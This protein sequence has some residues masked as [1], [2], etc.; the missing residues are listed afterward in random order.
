M[1]L[2]VSLSE[3]GLHRPSWSSVT[4]LVFIDLSETTTLSLHG[5]SVL[6][7]ANESPPA[8]TTSAGNTL[9]SGHKVKKKTLSTVP[10][11]TPLEGEEITGGTT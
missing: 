1:T 7:S 3:S 8:G 5:R 11:L 10:E 9:L 6:T 4:F 2:R